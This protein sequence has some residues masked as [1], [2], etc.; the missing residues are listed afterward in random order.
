MLIFVHQS[1]LTLFYLT[2]HHA[3]SLSLRKKTASL[4][5]RQRRILRRISLLSLVTISFS[6]IP[7]CI[8]GFKEATR[9]LSCEDKWVN[10]I[11]WNGVTNCKVQ[12]GAIAVA[13][14]S[15]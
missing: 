15:T 13:V 8:F 11:G 7:A 2:F 9:S 12:K 4:Y 1:G 3:V 5:C 14:L 6:W 10:N